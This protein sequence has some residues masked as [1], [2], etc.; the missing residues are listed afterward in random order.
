MLSVLVEVKPES[1]DV[2]RG[3]ILDLR[4]FQEAA[5]V[6]YSQL[7]AA[8]PAL[9]FMAMTVFKDDQYDPILVLEAN[10]DGASGP[11]WSQLEAAIGERL[12]DM[13]RCA[14]PPRDG[15]L[16]LFE[17][18][19]APG[20]RA[21]VA[22]YL[23]ALTLRP[24]VFHQG[25]RGLDR[26]RIEDEGALFAAVQTE[27]DTGAYAPALSAQGVHDSLRGKLAPRFALLSAPAPARV[28]PAENLADLARLLSFA[29]A[30]VLILCAPGLVLS[31]LV[32]PLPA[33]ALALILAVPLGLALPGFG[34]LLPKL[35]L[36]GT[37]ALV[38][39]LAVFVAVM[40]AVAA[41][42]PFPE[43]D[44]FGER[45]KG[46]AIAFGLGL[47]WAVPTVLVILV[48]LRGLERRDPSQDAPPVD[49][50]EQRLIAAREDQIAQNHMGSVVHLKPGAL[51]AVLI[52]AGLWGLGLVLRVTAHN[53]YLSSM[54]TIHFA[55]WAI[56]PDGARL[57]FF[58][59]FDSSWESYLDDFIEK[60]HPGLTLAW[61]SGTGFPPTRFLML[62]GATQGRRFKAWAR[63]SMAESLFWFSAYKS[64]TVNQIER[65]AR[66]ADGLR[67][68]ALT[69][70]EAAVWALDL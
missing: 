16:A 36:K 24:A 56:T 30:V 13:L 23:E 31:R 51:R 58:S 9:H 6:Q 25:N 2:L 12:R 47:C 43:G 1:A 4:A 8:V 65:Q 28:T 54:R 49:A 21:P 5:S 20:S 45:S 57:M 7:K 40:S 38:V 53:G 35:S 37:A 69:A 29:L 22:P 27:L 70:T 44:D 26:A 60:A 64:F 11:F 46:W 66:I 63:H 14:K 50:L 59:N 19:T 17:A 34:E 32:P 41:A 61:S 39:G 18:V 62:D 10:F 3:L 52:R 68:P 55:H 33:A 42:V 15:G 67:K 48:R